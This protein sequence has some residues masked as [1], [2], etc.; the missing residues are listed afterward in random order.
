MNSNEFYTTSTT[1]IFDNEWHY[2]QAV[3]DVSSDTV[4]LYIDG[5][6]DKTENDITT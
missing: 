4:K 2:V 6:L 1:S 5:I 3:R